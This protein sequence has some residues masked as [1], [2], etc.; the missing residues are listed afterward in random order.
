VVARRRRDEIL[1]K[2]RTEGRTREE[3]ARLLEISRQSIKEREKEV[4]NMPI[5]FDIFKFFSLSYKIRK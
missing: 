4:K 2:L 3:V 1:L 5:I